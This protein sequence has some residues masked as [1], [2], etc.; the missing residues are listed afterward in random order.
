VYSKKEI[1][2][3]NKKE[4]VKSAFNLDRPDRYSLYADDFKWTDSVG[5]PPL[6]KNS[7]FG[8]EEP[9]R[10]AVPDLS[11]VIDDIKEDGDYIVIASHFSGTF[12]KDLDLSSMGMGVIPATGKAFASPSQRDRVSF[13]GDKISELHNLETGPDAGMAGFIKALGV[14]TG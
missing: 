9:L 3:V 10:L 5:S 12:R 4:L 14:D 1:D 7:F 13:D 8:G 2:T 6:D 11:I